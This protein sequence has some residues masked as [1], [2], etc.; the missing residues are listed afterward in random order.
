MDTC[1]CSPGDAPEVAARSH[2]SRAE[3]AGTDVFER[4][5]AEVRVELAQSYAPRSTG[6]LGTAVRSFAKF[7]RRVPNHVLFTMPRVR[8]DLEAEARNEWTL[9]LW[10]H[11]LSRE[12]SGKTGRLLKAKTIES[13]VSLLKGLLSH[14]YGFAL[15]GESPRLKS[16]LS[17]LRSKDPLGN[18]RKK[19]RGMRRRH[20]RAL[21]EK[22][23]AVRA[24]QRHARIE[25]AAATAAWHVLARG[26]ELAA[27]TRADLQFKRMKGRRYAI[28]WVA[29]LKKRR[30]QQQQKL[31]QF[32]AEQ[33]GEDWEPYQALRRL[34]EDL[35]G[36]GHAASQPLFSG[37]GNKGITTGQYRA[38]LKRYARMLG[39]DPKDFGAHSTRIGGAIDLTAQGGCSQLILEG[40][41]RWS[42]D[43]GKIYARMTRR[44]QLA[45][46]DMMHAAR[47]RDL[48]ELM[49]EFVE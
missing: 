2:L 27:I 39:F 44:M 19:R 43:I 3:D 49:P 1:S 34:A 37:R 15:A 14:R 28:L 8:G 9:I 12:V 42:S 23:A 38:L 45:A 36:S 29:P 31:P 17:R 24:T 32:I 40:K 6:P 20:F 30:G 35:D 13:R 16:Y 21:W 18:T 4:L 7:A 48:E 47:G 46:S 5:D 11:D 33:P 25:W 22:H 26:G 10:A 41:G